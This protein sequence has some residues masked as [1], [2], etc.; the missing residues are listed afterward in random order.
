MLST[1]AS[2]GGSGRTNCRKEASPS[3][4][5]ATSQQEPW[6]DQAHEEE[7]GLSPGRCLALEDALLLRPPEASQVKK[8]QERVASDRKGLHRT[9]MASPKTTALEHS[10]S[11]FTLTLLVGE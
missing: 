3:D 6:Q 7:A 1:R 5:T 4:S 10:H 8:A 2:R 9:G 11:E